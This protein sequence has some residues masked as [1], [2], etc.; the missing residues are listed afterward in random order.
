MAA[1]RGSGQ[2]G[3]ICM[4]NKEVTG[5]QASQRGSPGSWFRLEGPGSGGEANF[6]DLAEQRPE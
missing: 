6:F 2:L 5:G 3:L 1:K 4:E